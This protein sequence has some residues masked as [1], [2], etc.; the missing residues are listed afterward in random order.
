MAER[1]ISTGEPSQTDRPLAPR[2]RSI[3]FRA[4]VVGSLLA[5]GVNLLTPFNDYVI[6]NTFMVGSYLPLALMLA[7]F[8]LVMIGNGLLRAVLPRQAFSTGEIAVMLMML[9]V[10]CSI[11]SQGLL[12][13][14]VPSLTTPFYYG[15]QNPSYFDALRRA[16]IP[17][18]LFPAPL[19]D[20]RSPTSPIIK[21][22]YGKVSDG[23]PIPYG[24]WIRPILTWGVY[25]VG[26]FSACVALAY[27]L[28][29]QWADNERLPFPLVQLQASLIEAPEP[30][31][32]LNSLFRHRSFWITAAA[33]LIVHSFN[34]LHLYNEKV[35]PEIPRAYDFT[36]FTSEPPWSYFSDVIRRNTIY[37]TFIGATFFIRSR[38]AFSIWFI[39]LLMHGYQA[40]RNSLQMPVPGTQTE[41]QHIGACLAF[42]VSIVWIGRAL[43]WNALKGAFGA[44]NNAGSDQ[45]WAMRLL[46]FGLVIMF[47]WMLIAGFHPIL[48]VV[49]IIMVLMAHVV[50]GRIVAET[51][52]PYLRTNATVLQLAQNLPADSIS[53]RDTFFAGAMSV[54]GAVQT[55]E[56]IFGLSQHGM[57]LMDEVGAL[58]RRFGPLVLIIGW[59]LVIS[60]A[61]AWWSS[62][63][64]YY[65]Y[66]APISSRINWTMLNQDIATNHTKSTLVDSVV[67]QTSGTFPQKAYDARV[68]IAIGFGVV[69]LLQA[70]AWTFA[71]WPLLPIGFVLSGTPLIN[72]AW[73]SVLLGWLAKVVLQKLGGNRLLAD[74]RPVFI[75]LI[76]GE[77]L[78]AAIWMLI[79]FFLAMGGF[80]YFRYS[81]LPT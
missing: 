65:S 36:S 59:T 5:V 29:T 69:V 32:A 50:T 55:R 76:F 49:S 79:T 33:I 7:T 72:N 17:D 27:L 38:T 43:F 22:F 30:G 70:G 58:R 40:F 42:M 8:F 62:L 52:I 48:A 66:S 2:E 21:N 1:H 74:A 68:H 61:A 53:T 37:F 39:F 63:T 47:G 64:C 11:P 6:V 13:Q 44:A 20:E 54:N 57:R 71:G 24:P 28:R 4:L 75:G 56:S 15:E 81:A 25:L 73:F 16:G 67:A 51:G 18:W 80:D 9:L 35:W 3:T 77:A 12:R 78:A 41:D 60:L 45:A 19:S 10:A 26:F 46:M 31:R 14:L 23:E 34:A